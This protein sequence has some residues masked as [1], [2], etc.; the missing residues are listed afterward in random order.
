MRFLFA[1]ACLGLVVTSV[2]AQQ[3]RKGKCSGEAPDSVWLAQGPV[4]LD[5]EV[6]QKASHRGS[7]PRLDLTPSSFSVTETRCVRAVLEFV[8]DAAGQPE[9]ATIRPRPGNDRTL[10]DA[11]RQT[12]SALRYTPAQ[13]GGQPVRQ[14]VVYKRSLSAVARSSTQPVAPRPSANC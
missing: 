4:Y 6:D 8:V 5:C 13:L 2:D 7:E 3:A 1:L 12:I 9:I 14:L 11:V 10:E